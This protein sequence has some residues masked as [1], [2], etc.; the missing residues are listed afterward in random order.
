MALTDAQR[1]SVLRHLGFHAVSQSRFPIVEGFAAIGTILDALA[2][3]PAT[4]TEVIAILG[5]LAALETALDGARSRLKASE[6]GSIT[7]NADEH[8]QLWREIKRWRG[9]LSTIVGI[10]LRHTGG[11]LMV[12]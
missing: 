2:D 9:E 10:P 8:D 6:V 3:T 12:V 7:L 1:T 11:A 4:E 5:R